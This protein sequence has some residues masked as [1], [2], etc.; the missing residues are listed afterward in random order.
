MQNPQRENHLGV[1]KGQ[2]GEGGQYRH[3][4]V[5]EAESDEVRSRDQI[6]QNLVTL[7]LFWWAGKTLECFHQRI[8]MTSHVLRRGQI[9]GYC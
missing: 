7:D 2:G 6:K 4:K 3:N 9:R 5:V 8:A 1:F